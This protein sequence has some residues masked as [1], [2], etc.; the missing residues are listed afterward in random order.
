ML[1]HFAAW[2]AATPLSAFVAGQAWVVPTVQTLHILAVCVVMGAAVV[3]N[4]RVLRVV[5]RDQSIGSLAARFVPPSAVAIVILAITGLLMIA[6]EPTRAIFRSVF[7]WKMGLL[8]AA[9]ALTA[10]LLAGLKA[11]GVWDDAQTPTP[12]AFRGLAVGL[13]LV[14]VAIIIAGRWIGYTEGWPGSPS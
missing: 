5:E 13:L 12:V 10:G 4:L 3:L 9:I 1:E 2:L 14:W 6:G 7:W 8:A 11:Q